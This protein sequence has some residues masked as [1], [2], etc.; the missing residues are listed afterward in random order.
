MNRRS[1]LKWA[2]L[3]GLAAGFPSAS[4]FAATP[5]DAQAGTQE[6]ASA[7]KN[8]ASPNTILLKDYRPVSIYKIPVTQVAKAKF[9]IIDMH[10]HP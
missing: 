1:F 4:A 9:P 3:T 6:Q 10:S 8:A 5:A 2:N 7:K